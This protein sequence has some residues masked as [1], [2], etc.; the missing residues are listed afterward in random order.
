[1]NM[2]FVYHL[3][4][5]LFFFLALVLLIVAIIELLLNLLDYTIFRGVYSA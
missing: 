4:G 5:R 1:M 2:T 3:F